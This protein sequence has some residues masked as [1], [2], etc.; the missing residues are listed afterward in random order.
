METP[1]VLVVNKNPAKWNFGW[2]IWIAIVFFA[3]GI[4]GAIG[5]GYGREQVVKET[6][7]TTTPEDGWVVGVL[8]KTETKSYPVIRD[9]KLSLV[10]IDNNNND[11]KSVIVDQN[12]LS[13]NGSIYTGSTDPAVPPDI[14]KIAYLK[15]GGQAWLI[16]ANSKDK[17][18]LS[19]EILFSALGSWSPDSR[20]LILFSKNDTVS[21]LYEGMGVEDYKKL[22]E[23][24]IPSGVFLYDAQTGNISWL[25]PISNVVTWVGPTKLLTLPDPDQTPS[26]YVIF[27]VES[28]EADTKTLRN[29][30]EKWFYPQFSMSNGSKW[31]LSLGRTGNESQSSSYSKI[32]IADFPDAEGTLIEEG[33]WAYIQKPIISPKGDKAIYRKYDVVNGPVYVEY[34]NEGKIARLVEG[35]PVMWIDGNRF[36]YTEGAGNIMLRKSYLYDIVSKES[37]L[38]E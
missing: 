37:K 16:S 22:K 13:G 35:E 23:T 34:W 36:I 11:T 27:D 20:Y 29:S 1:G 33:K 26:G 8:P 2:M 21:S 10:S 25:S 12:V 38:L 17:I 3:F 14:N 7:A 6:T 28:Y 32:V 24:N 19:K 5:L 18:L 9:G 30:F 4:G 31:A 15:D